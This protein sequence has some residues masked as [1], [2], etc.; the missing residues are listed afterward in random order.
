MT[1]KATVR[2]GLVVCWLAFLFL[3]G[4]FLTTQRGMAA[5]E[6]LLFSSSSPYLITQT[7]DALAGWDT[8]RDWSLWAFEKQGVLSIEYSPAYTRDHTL[9]VSVYTDSWAALYR[10]TDGGRTW[11]ALPGWT[12]PA[13]DIVLSPNY[14][15]DH[16]LFAAAGTNGG[17]RRS[18]D[19]G[20]SWADTGPVSATIRTL[21]IS[22]HYAADRTLFAGA[23]DGRVFR[24]TDG[25]LTWN[26]L[27]VL[28]TDHR[29]NALAISPNYAAD[30]TIFAGVGKPWSW[31][32]GGVYRSTDG[33]NTW[34]VVNNGLTNLK[35][36]S[37][38]IS[39][40]YANDHTL[41][42]TVWD[43]GVYRS[44][45]G[46]ASWVAANNGQPNRR[47]SFLLISPFYGQ[48][49]T[50]F[51]GTWGDSPPDYN[52]GV[53]VT[54][55]GGDSWQ[56]V[57]VNLPNHFI[58]Q[59]AVAPN[60]DEDPILLAG[61][62]Y[63]TDFYLFGGLWRYD[64]DG[65]AAL[66]I[67]KTAP[68]Q[69]EVGR[70]ITYTLTVTNS[71]TATATGVVITD[72]IPGNAHYLRGGLKMGNIV[73][74][75]VPTLPVGA[76]L[77]V[78]WVATAAT[79]VVN[80]DYRVVAKGGIT[81]TGRSAIVTLIKGCPPL[82][83]YLC[84]FDE[85]GDP[86]PGAMVF[87]NGTLLTDATGRPRLTNG[88]GLLTTTTLYEGETLAAL[89]PLYE[90]PT[91]K[92]A[93][94]P[95]GGGNFAFRVYRTTM[96]VSKDG[97]VSPYIVS[98]GALPHLLTTRPTQT[99]VLFDIV[100][101][102]EWDADETYMA[103][104]KNGL[105]WASQ[106][107]YDAT[108]GQMAFGWITVYD[109]GAHWEDA[110]IQ[111][112]AH[113]HTRPHA[114][115]GGI[116]A[117]LPPGSLRYQNFAP[118][119]GH[120][121]LG[122]YW[123]GYG[124]NAGSWDAYD[125]AATIAHEFGHYG[126][127]LFDEYFYYDGEGRYRVQRPSRCSIYD[128]DPA[129]LMYFPYQTTYPKTEFCSRPNQYPEFHGGPPTRQTQV[130]GPLETSWKTLQGVYSDTLQSLGGIAPWRIF[131][132]P[133]RGVSFVTGPQ[134]I[135]LDLLQIQDASQQGG[136]FGKK[137]TVKYEGQPVWGA[138]VAVHRA[139]GRIIN[140]GLTDRYGNIDLLGVRIG[141]V[142]QAR[143]LDNGLGGRL[144][145]QNAAWET[146]PLSPVFG[147]LRRGGGTS[148]AP[149]V[150]IVP[151]ADGTTIDYYAE[152]TG[153]LS[154]TVRA[155]VTGP[156]APANASAPMTY[157]GNA[158]HYF[159]TFSGF[160]TGTLTGL[161][162][163]MSATETLSGS[164]AIG[165][166]HDRSWTG[167]PSNDLN[168]TTTDGNLTLNAPGNSFDVPTY[169]IANP[170][171]ALPGPV[172]AG[173]VRVGQAYSIQASGAVT[174]PA[175]A[176]ALTLSYQPLSLGG[177]DVATLRPHYW[178]ANAGGSGAWTPVISYTLDVTANQVSASVTRFGIYMLMGR[179]PPPIIHAITPMTIAYAT[180][181]AAVIKGDHFQD[182]AQVRI[183]QVMTLTGSS[184]VFV[185]EQTLLVSIPSTLPP[186]T[187]DIAVINPDGQ[188]ALL[189][190]GLTV[191]APADRIYLPLI[192][193]L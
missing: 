120:I 28:L 92:N 24:T 101:S 39:P 51:Y 193:K 90:H 35:A 166:A 131:S 148:G 156:Q 34:Q 56:T 68:T 143:T 130:Y 168:L 91:D 16:T 47:P 127:F 20:D 83:N 93:H 30:R 12:V 7:T 21:A 82:T 74:W 94:N 150:I 86:A 132:P 147:R 11:V 139:D 99:L 114:Y 152:G 115:V 118:E 179:T 46:G 10:T 151:R 85:N 89:W 176:M 27:G 122:R 104:L 110:D 170:T 144:E 174:G 80:A 112:L 188:L 59:L 58:H 26:D 134:Q 146:L 162:F 124:S 128:T 81:A 180:P 165:I 171:N 69:V 41:F 113:N 175:K 4:A 119:P 70:P 22:P 67:A 191:Q 73:R 18:T 163:Q 149:L 192:M 164:L 77:R 102:V 133:Q 42:V 187:Y 116:T 160:P 3:A 106:M 65:Q 159:V 63:R 87:R 181:T 5:D 189:P 48:D 98:A 37:L 23:D 125:G 44:L 185:D 17:V 62:H 29:V 64:F 50:V 177:V 45:D 155:S 6:S 32:T 13:R 108:D 61:A 123:N 96:P 153:P 36:G 126:L 173:W 138:I 137:L 135:P 121:V 186:G 145:V 136:A 158:N 40:D 33:G 183:G 54:T 75:D 1:K 53:Y 78:Q 38:I 141:D 140:Q 14:A 88:D 154:G 52:D 129:S 109:D 178:S 8:N 161:T 76:P 103:E 169:V 84:V 9:F 19:G 184:V 167:N 117:A 43:G 71:G 57:N 107:L 95:D 190:Q 79:T 2:Y 172:P 111:I 72:R 105:I 60:F 97:Q 55:D 49:K 31:Y 157:D 100:A 66:S 142:V 15:Q 182:G 25:G